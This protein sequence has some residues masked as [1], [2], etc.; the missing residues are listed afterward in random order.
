[1]LSKIW[2][3]SNLLAFMLSILWNISESS[4]NVKKSLS[5]GQFHPFYLSSLTQISSPSSSGFTPTVSQMDQCQHSMVS[6]FF[7][8]SIYVH[9]V[10]YHV[11]LQCTFI[12]VGQFALLIICLFPLSCGSITGRQGN[13][14]ATCFTV[15]TWTE[16]QIRG[17]WSPTNFKRN[18]MIHNRYLLLT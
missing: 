6:C 5:L 8:S 15:C 4:C 3:A 2:S 11:S 18:D 12:F 1:M 16:W 9:S 14:T 17:D 10:C 13:H 7:Y